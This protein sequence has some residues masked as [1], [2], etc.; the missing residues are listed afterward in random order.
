MSPK[1]IIYKLNELKDPNRRRLTDSQKEA[2][3][4]AIASVERLMVAKEYAIKKDKVIRYLCPACGEFM[5]FR[6]SLI[7]MTFN[8]CPNCGQ[9][10]KLPKE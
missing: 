2:I 3:D 5:G 1:S 9:K 10:L 4:K 8:H 6:Y 7:K